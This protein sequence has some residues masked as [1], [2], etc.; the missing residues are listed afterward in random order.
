MNK[1]L[2]YRVRAVT[3]YV[4]TE[5]TLVGG[6]SKGTSECGE[7]KTADQANLAAHGLAFAY[8]GEGT[9]YNFPYEG[10][11]PGKV[12]RCKVVL[13][14]RQQAWGEAPRDANGKPPGRYE[15]R[16]WE[17][18]GRS[19]VF[20][21]ADPTDPANIVLDGETLQFSAVCPPSCGGSAPENAIFGQYT[22]NFDLRA[23]VRNPDVLATLE[24]GRE[25]YVDFTPAPRG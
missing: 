22:P 20:I 12:M 23:H 2:E 10:P 21:Y 6:E 14:G 7:F 18:G 16:P 19:G 25:Y 4:V 1:V 3:R 15:E 17:S 5:H 9:S 11:P 13:H 24:Q 8:R